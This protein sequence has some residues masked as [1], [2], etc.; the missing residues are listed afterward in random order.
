[1]SQPDVVRYRKGTAIDT[2]KALE[3]V[4]LSASDWGALDA[5][6]PELAGARGAAF[7]SSRNRT[8]TIYPPTNAPLQ[9]LDVA[10]AVGNERTHT[11]YEGH[12]SGNLVWVLVH[13]HG[14]YESLHIYRLRK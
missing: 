8:V 9:V 6:Y 3:V 12:E 1:M 10:R 4:G 5:V 2:S 14:G 11:V 13:V 7:R